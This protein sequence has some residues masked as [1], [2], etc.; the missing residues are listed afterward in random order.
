MVWALIQ[1]VSILAIVALLAYIG[2]A[3]AKLTK[4]NKKDLTH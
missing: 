1:I 3:D 4:S 2:I